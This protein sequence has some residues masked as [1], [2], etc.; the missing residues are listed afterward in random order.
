MIEYNKKDISNAIM[1]AE[2][3]VKK[4]VDDEVRRQTIYLINETRYDL[5]K[6]KNVEKELKSLCK[7]AMKYSCEYPEAFKQLREC[8]D[9]YAVQVKSNAKSLMNIINKFNL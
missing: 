5:I 7:I 3:N 9:E 8:K 1:T 2:K 6:L 4:I